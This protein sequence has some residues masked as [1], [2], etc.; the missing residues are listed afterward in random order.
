MSIKPTTEKPL[1]PPSNFSSPVYKRH[2]SSSYS[3]SSLSSLSSDRPTYLSLLMTGR[4]HR[5]LIEKQKPS[6]TNVQ[7]YGK[8]LLN[9][10][11]DLILFENNLGS[12]HFTLPIFTFLFGV[13][14]VNQDLLSLGLSKQSAVFSKQEKH[15]NY[16]CRLRSKPHLFVLHA[17]VHL[18]GFLAGGQIIAK[19]LK[20]T[21]WGKDI[22]HLYEFKPFNCD[23]YSSCLSE[24]ND[25]MNCLSES[26]FQEL[27]EEIPLAWAFAEDLFETNA[28]NPSSIF[29]FRNIYT[30]V[31]DFF[32]SLCRRSFY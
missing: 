20:T 29:N 30:H 26:E 16:I 10:R 1:D 7:D 12:L 5:S 32:F 3:S 2:P 18:L 24:L 28:S 23:Y 4:Y 15:A 31:S 11:H 9:L 8:Y 27:K 25:Y 22:V 19:N 13:K 6:L 17:S 21:S 14:G